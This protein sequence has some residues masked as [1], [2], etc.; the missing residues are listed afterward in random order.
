MV[1]IYCVRDQ[2]LGYGQLFTAANDAVAIRDFRLAVSRKDSLMFASAKD[3][4]LM[5]LG[6]FDPEL[7]V[8]SS[9]APVI[10]ASGASIVKEFESNA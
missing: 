8:I 7:G 1:K 6:T 2:Y 10:V 5:C 4:D 3:F 9:E